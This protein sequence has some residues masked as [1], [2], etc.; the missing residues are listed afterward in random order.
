M[1]SVG[2]VEDALALVSDG[3]GEDVLGVWSPERRSAAGSSR[4]PFRRQPDPD[5]LAVLVRPVVVRAA[6]HPPPSSQRSGCPQRQ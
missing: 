4:T 1:R 3:G 6:V 2:S 5:H